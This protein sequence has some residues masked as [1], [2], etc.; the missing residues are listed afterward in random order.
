MDTTTLGNWLWEAACTIRGPLDAPKFKD[1][2]LPLIFLK[3]LSSVCDDEV[4]DLAQEVGDRDATA[5]LVEQDHELVRHLWGGPLGS[6]VG[7]N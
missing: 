7:L 4:D 5:K 6:Q 2:I 1:D 3:R